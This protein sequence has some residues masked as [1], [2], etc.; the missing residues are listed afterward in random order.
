[1]SEGPRRRKMKKQHPARRNEEGNRDQLMTVRWKTILFPLGRIALAVLLVGGSVALAQVV[2]KALEGLL[3]AGGAAP[4]IYYIAYLIASVLVAYFV[5]Q[6]YVHFVEK[7]AVT[8][9]S[10]PGA[11]SELGV[12]M[13]VGFGL[14]SAWLIERTI[15]PHLPLHPVSRY[16]G[17]AG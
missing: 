12:G 11:P 16:R 2:V 10:G 9:L 7:R 4:A 14:V 3:S 1:M 13:L 17:Q 5:Y 15:I 8:E 6:A